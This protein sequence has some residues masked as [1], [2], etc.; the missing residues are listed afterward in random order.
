[1]APIIFV[2]TDSNGLCSVGTIF[3]AAACIIMSTSSAALLSLSL[4]LISPKKS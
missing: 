2:F 4:S 1:M 3:N